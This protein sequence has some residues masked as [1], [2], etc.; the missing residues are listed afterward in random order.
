[1]ICHKL[2]INYIDKKFKKDITLKYNRSF[3][4]KKNSRFMNIIE[5]KNILN[6]KDVDI[7]NAFDF[8]AQ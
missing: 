1:M 4:Q 2:N 3:I 8:I 6:F 5:F 7:K